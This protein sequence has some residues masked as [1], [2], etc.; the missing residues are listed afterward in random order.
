MNPHPFLHSR[1]PRISSSPLYCSTG[2]LSYLLIQVPSPQVHPF[3]QAI[4]CITSRVLFLYLNSDHVIPCL[5]SLMTVSRIQDKV[6]TSYHLF[7]RHFVSAP[8]Q[9]FGLHTFCLLRTIMLHS[10]WNVQLSHLHLWVLFP[11]LGTSHHHHLLTLRLILQNSPE[12]WVP[13]LC[14]CSL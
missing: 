3:S 6:Q 13:A 9:D 8:S 1:W 2:W 10:C 5:K 11:I 14:S 4:L 7:R 12:T